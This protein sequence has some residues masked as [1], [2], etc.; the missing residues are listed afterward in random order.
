MTFRVAFT[1]YGEKGACQWGSM[2]N[3][4]RINNKLA[5]RVKRARADDEAKTVIANFQ[6]V[7]IVQKIINIENKC[8][9]TRFLEYW[10]LLSILRKRYTLSLSHSV[11]A[12]TVVLYSKYNDKEEKKKTST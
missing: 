8:Q 9:M 1:L 3:F 6:I 4:S 12:T 10:I 11:K 2:K 5:K 7:N